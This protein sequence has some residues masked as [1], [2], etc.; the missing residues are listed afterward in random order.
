MIDFHPRSD[1]IVA[2]VRCYMIDAPLYSRFFFLIEYD[3]VKKIE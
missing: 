1:Y 2:V 3:G